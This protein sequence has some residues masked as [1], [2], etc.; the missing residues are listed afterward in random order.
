MNNHSN[1][2]YLAMAC[3]LALFATTACAEQG[4]DRAIQ[5]G[6]DTVTSP[7]RIFQG[8]QDDTSTYG[9][10]GVVT[11]SLK[12]GAA[13]AGQAVTGAANIGVGVLEALTS[14]LRQ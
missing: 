5:G 11:G 10:A 6:T 4:V 13:A 8:I 3:G 7:V 12:G 1:Y 14:P 9:P 2:S